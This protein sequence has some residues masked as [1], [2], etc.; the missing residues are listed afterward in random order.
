MATH[1]EIKPQKNPELNTRGLQM[2]HQ[3][4]EEHEFI[5]RYV[6][7]QLTPEDRR[8]FQEH[9]FTC[10]ECF[11]RVQM[12]ERFIAGVRYA[13][14]TGL[15]DPIAGDKTEAAAVPSWPPRLKVLFGFLI[16]AALVLG[17]ILG[18]TWLYQMPRMREQIEQAGRQKLTQTTEQLRLEKE[19]R[20]KLQI[21]TAENQL[22]RAIAPQVNVPLVI[23]QATRDSSTANNELIVPAG[24]HNLILWIEVEQ[25]AR[26]REF[27]LRLYSA[28]KQ[29]VQTVEGLKRNPY[30]ALAVSLPAQPFQTGRYLVE[31][32][33][34]AQ[35]QTT[36]VEDYSL[37][38]QKR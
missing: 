16:L 38:V 13:G 14:E 26:F 28:Q 9:F 15:L 27:R 34:L 11:D 31:L 29:L 20:A 23:L 2:T 18:W 7:N 35:Q 21:Q 24:A 8:R 22:S 30:G 4:I 1:V 3:E 37:Q 32:Y 25:S 19:A 33:G 10:D 17:A 12:A 5:E 36:L 6:G